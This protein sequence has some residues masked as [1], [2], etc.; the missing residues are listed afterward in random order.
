MLGTN[1]AEQVKKVHLSNDTIPRRI[2]DISSD[3]KSQIY[4]HFEA[5][6]VSSS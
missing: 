1:A 4:E 5:P 3:L 6:V 2:E